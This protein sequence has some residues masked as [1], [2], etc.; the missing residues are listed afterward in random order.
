MSPVIGLRSK[1]ITIGPVGSREYVL[2]GRL[3]EVGPVKTISLDINKEHVVA[4]VGKR[5]SGKTH[6]LGV[7]VE[8]LGVADPSSVLGINS[9]ERAILVFDTLNLF[10]WIGL[11]L[12]STNGAIVK[13]QLSKAKLWN[14]PLESVNVNLWHL[15]GSNPVTQDSSPFMIRVSEMYAQ[16]WGLLMDVDIMMEPMGQLIAAACDK[17][18][19][20]GW[21]T[22]IGHKGPI[23]NHS[24]NDLIACINE[25]VELSNEFA[26]D[27]RRA[28]RQRLL[29]YNSIGLF[30]SKGTS[31]KELLK[32]GQISVL[33]LGR[34]PEDLRTLVSFLVMR[35]LLEFR[36][37]ASEKTKDS[38]IRGSEQGTT[39]IPK[40]WVVIDEAQN[41]IPSRTASI[42]NKELT[43]FVREGRNFGL[44]VAVST[45]QPQAIDQNIMSQV[46]VLIAHTLTV[47]SDINYILNNIKGALPENIA[48]GRRVMRIQ[49]AIRELEIGQCMISGVEAPRAFFT[50]VRPR[51]SPHGGFEA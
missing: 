39:G 49:D 31:L 16:D 20:T 28:I 26:P 14:L 36:S 10:Q 12:T 2:L 51:I 21:N 29:S 25:D 4:I 34:T 23:Q 18:A 32:P 44:S 1:S 41:I 13:E 47:Q 37:L 33:L 24:I 40:T 22:S 43:R 30:S 8:G 17:V 19:R 48:V 46:D 27:T 5:G 9:R 38:M 45:Q 35:R 6:T 7:I 42:A 3:A 15:A 11:S 50:E